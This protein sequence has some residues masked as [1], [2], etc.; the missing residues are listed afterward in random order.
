ME[1]ELVK[2]AQMEVRALKAAE[3]GGEGAARGSSRRR[4]CGRNKKK[5]E[6]GLDEDISGWG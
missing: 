6:D 3:K 2:E 1:A 5:S 4:V